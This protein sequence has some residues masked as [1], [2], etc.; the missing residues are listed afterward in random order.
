[1]NTEFLEQVRET[2]PDDYLRLG[3]MSIVAEY[4]ERGIRM[5]YLA[6]VA[7]IKVNGVAELHSQL[8]RDKVLNDFAE[9]WP[10]KFT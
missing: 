5:A 7:G 10:D 6:T 4:P 3:R 8:L 9:L 2:W 1:I